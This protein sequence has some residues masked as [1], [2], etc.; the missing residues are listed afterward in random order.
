MEKRRMLSQ[1]IAKG[2]VI[3]S[4]VLTHSG[5]L[6]DEHP[7]MW[8]I[9]FI[10]CPMGFFF[11]ISGYNYRPGRRK[12]AENIKNRSKQLII[13]LVCYSLG[14][15]VVMFILNLIFGFGTIKGLL[16]SL[17]TSLT[18]TFSIDSIVLK[19]FVDPSLATLS[20]YNIP[21]WFVV[22]MFLGYVI[23]FIVVDYALLSTK[24][25]FSIVIGLMSI[26][27]AL[28]I[29]LDK[30]KPFNPLGIIDVPS[31]AA[32]LLIGA[33]LGQK[34]LF[35]DGT[36]EKKWVVINSIV[37][38]GL[39]TVFTITY[40][41]AGM[42]LGG[43]LSLV[44]GCAEIPIT[45]IMAVLFSYGLIGLCKLLERVPVL[46]PAMCWL[47]KNSL[48]IYFVHMPVITLVKFFLGIDIFSGPDK[49]TITASQY[50]A[51]FFITLVITIAVVFIIEQIK[52]FV[53]KRMRKK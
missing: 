38:L 37:G 13:P 26:S 10:T 29:A 53:K 52:A 7:L 46:S 14:A 49:S 40:P 44:L 23:F 51:I 21:S 1:D 4:V 15:F 2:I 34:G 12:I 8:F 32:M 50:M 16:V 19:Y 24:K 20:V 11:L 18:G 47:G 48:G 5:H 41:R 6:A 30:I 28:D 17:Y 3:L 33:Y 9:Y 45:L 25:M 36:V 35:N 27:M 42:M 43:N 22:H 39:C 31:I